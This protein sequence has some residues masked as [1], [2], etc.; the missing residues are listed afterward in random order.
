MGPFVFPFVQP[1]LNL[2]LSGPDLLSDIVDKLEL[3]K[4]LLLGHTI[5]TDSDT[6]EA[7]LGADA[8]RLESLLK[9]AALAV[10]DDLGSVK[11][12]VLDDLGVLQLG[13][14]GGDDTEDDVLVLGEETEGLETAGAGVVVL[15]EEGVVV[16]RREELFGDLFV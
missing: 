11:D 7:A 3:G 12:S 15:E 9:A 13:L 6:S 16:E 8:D 4:H 14:L 1:S 2:R 5:S 10:G